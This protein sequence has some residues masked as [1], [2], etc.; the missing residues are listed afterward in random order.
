M[1]SILRFGGREN[2]WNGT[3]A[4]GFQVCATEAV[5]VLVEVHHLEAVELVGDFLDLLCLTGLDDFYAGG[6]PVSLSSA[7]FLESP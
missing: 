6:V 1:V 4:L 5:V 2:E 7:A 3:Y